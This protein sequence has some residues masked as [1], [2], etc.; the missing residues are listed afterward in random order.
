MVRL[1]FIDPLIEMRKV[2]KKLT[3]PT[4]RATQESIK[5]IINTFWGLLTS[6]Y[7]DVNNV[8]C[9]EFVSSSTRCSVWL[10]SKALNTH[11]SIT[12]GGP[13]SLMFNV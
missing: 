12:D 5:L 8:V 6:P 9:S 11:S 10:M 3:D 13:Y 7:F 1:S 2:L 4:S